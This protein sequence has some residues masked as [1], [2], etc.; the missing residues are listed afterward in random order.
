MMKIPKKIEYD[1]A[2]NVPVENKSNL[3]E[4]KFLQLNFN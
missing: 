4:I 3:N 2:E 1:R